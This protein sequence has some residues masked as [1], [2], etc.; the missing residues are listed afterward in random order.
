MNVAFVANYAADRARAFA[1]DVWTASSCERCVFDGNACGGKGGGVY[2]D[3]SSSPAF[4]DARFERNY[5]SD[6]GG[7]L[8]VDGSSA[9]ALTRVAIV[10]N[11]ARDAGGGLYVGTYGV[12]H[13]SVPNMPTLTSCT[14]A[15]NTAVGRRMSS[16]GRTTAPTS[17]RD[18]GRVVQWANDR[19]RTAVL[20]PVC[21]RGFIAL[22][23]VRRSRARSAVRTSALGHHD[24]EQRV[25]Y[26]LNDKNAE[27][28][29]ARCGPNTAAEDLVHEPDFEHVR[30]PYRLRGAGDDIR[31]RLACRRAD[32]REC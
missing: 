5:A 6:S 18:R 7:A 8:A 15:G 12:S 31:G 10:N 29:E 16:S 9:P 21:A 17:Q 19:A 25:D 26:L 11:T 1:N 28:R 23:R 30:C 14:I 27:G 24:Q 20:L 32:Q 22:P 3:Y 13:G 4:T 2:L